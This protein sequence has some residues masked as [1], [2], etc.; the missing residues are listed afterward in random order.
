M[1][2]ISVKEFWKDYAA[3]YDSGLNAIF[4]YIPGLQCV[5]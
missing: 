2:D 3:G 4:Y 1:P 5:I